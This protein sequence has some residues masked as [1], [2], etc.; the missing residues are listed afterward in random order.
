ML[1]I[2]SASCVLKEDLC[3]ER[4]TCQKLAVSV[5]CAGADD[6]CELMCSSVCFKIK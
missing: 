2:S 6:D 4:I 5:D 1:C 3:Q